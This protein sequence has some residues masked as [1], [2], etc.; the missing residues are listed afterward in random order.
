MAIYARRGDLCTVNNGIVSAAPH[1]MLGIVLSM[2]DMC[3][4]ANRFAVCHVLTG[5]FHIPTSQIKQGCDLIKQNTGRG[6]MNIKSKDHLEILD[7]QHVR[8][9]FTSRFIH[10]MHLM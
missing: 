7:E 9:M 1:I 8:T 4:K 10:L 5:I 6:L 2:T 3:V